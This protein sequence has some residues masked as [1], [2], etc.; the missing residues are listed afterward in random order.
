M[1]FFWCHYRQGDIADNWVIFNSA[2]SGTQTHVCIH[3]NT[4]QG[5]CH[6]SFFF[7]MLYF[8]SDMLSNRPTIQNL[9]EET[10]S[11]EKLSLPA[12]CCSLL[13]TASHSRC[14]LPGCLP[15]AG[16]LRHNALLVFKCIAVVV[17]SCVGRCGL[18]CSP[19]E[20]P[21]VTLLKHR[22]W[23]K[24]KNGSFLFVPTHPLRPT[25]GLKQTFWLDTRRP[26]SLSV[27][28][29][30]KSGSGSEFWPVDER[31][32][33]PRHVSL[34]CLVQTN[35]KITYLNELIPLC[36]LSLSN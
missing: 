27:W 29:E 33:E 14:C 13:L 24:V 9:S 15:K 11:F 12:T 22:L 17:M 1:C 26:M 31:R 21:C 16:A 18:R 35:W 6:I 5:H 20:A 4:T 19:L 8:L 36:A 32:R 2:A 25:V 10:K 3:F 23:R 28:Q 30:E 7:L 34:W